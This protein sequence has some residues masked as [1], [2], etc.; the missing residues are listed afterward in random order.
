LL[1]KGK[2]GSMNSNP[3]PGLVSR[4]QLLTKPSFADLRGA[5]FFRCVRLVG[6]VGI[7]TASLQNKSCTVN[8]IVPP[9]RFQLLLNVVKLQ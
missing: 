6:A 8:G 3:T 4:V 1:T 5:K 2:L 9:P 7:E